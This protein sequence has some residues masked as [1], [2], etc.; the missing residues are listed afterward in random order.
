MN[1]K[2]LLF[3]ATVSGGLLCGPA[4]STAAV[5]TDIAID[6]AQRTYAAPAPTRVVAP[7]GI[8]RRFEGETIR[9]KL[10]LDAAGQPVEVGL[11][12][13]QDVN[14]VRNLLPAVS[15]WR[16]SPALLDGRPVA[17][18]IELPILLVADPSA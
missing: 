16:F 7:S 12:G 3:L 10:S 18:Q 2:Q 14:L 1:A 13:S 5:V 4:L 6:S 17:A 11:V 15:Q 8:A 9:V